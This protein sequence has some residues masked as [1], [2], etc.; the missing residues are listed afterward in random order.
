[1]LDKSVK[2][3]G[4]NARKETKAI[5]IGLLSMKGMRP[6]AAELLSFRRKKYDL[7]WFSH[8]SES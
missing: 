6:N 7:K 1:M 5:K 4:I 2:D 8:Q 3:V